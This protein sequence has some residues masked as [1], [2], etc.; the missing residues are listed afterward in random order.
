MKDS[1]LRMWQS[2]SPSLYQGWPVF[3]NCALQ[4]LQS[5]E[6]SRVPQHT[7][8]PFHLPGGLSSVLGGLWEPRRE[9]AKQTNSSLPIKMPRKFYAPR[10]HPLPKYW[11]WPDN[12][13]QTA[14]CDLFLI[15][16]ENPSQRDARRKG[17]SAT[18]CALAED[19]RKPGFC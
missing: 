18:V 4:E 7:W 19:L 15:P 6:Y 3:P 11:V 16:N 2:A 14:S 1:K 17:S 13:K 5:A 12:S 8:L 10:Y 9:G